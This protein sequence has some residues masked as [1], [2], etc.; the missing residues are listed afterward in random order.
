MNIKK[1][2]DRP[3][4]SIVISVFIVLLGVI[5]LIGLPIEKYPNI[6][7]PT[8]TI[9]TNY[10]GASADAIQNSVIMPIEEAVNGVDDMIYI[11]S[12]ASNSGDVDISVYFKQG[13][14]ADMAAVNVQNR[15]SQVLGLLPAEVTKVGVSVNKRQPSMLRVFTLYSPGHT[16]DEA[17][18][19]NYLDINVVPALKRISG[20]GMT[21]LLASK[22]GMRV[23]VDPVMMAQYNLV[24][25]DIIAVLAEQNIEAPV[26]AFG[27]NADQTFL[28]SMKYRGRNVTEDEFEKIVIKTLPDG[29]ELYLRDVARLELGM[30]SYNFRDLANGAPG[31]CVMVFQVAG[32]NAT[33]I[34]IKIDKLFEELKA[35]MPADL[36]FA[37]LQNSNDFLFASIHNVT[38]SLVIAIILVILVV[39]FFLQDI[40]ATIIPSIS[41]IVSLLGTFVFLQVAGYTLNLL[42]L[43][44]LVLVIGTVVDDTIVIVEA[45]Q[46]R[47]DVGYKSAHKAIC[48][49]VDGLVGSLF[50]TTLVFMMVFIPV[51][52][53]GGTTG[54]FYR[55][56]GLSMAVAVG[57]SLLCAL[58]LAPA[59]CA[60]M[61][62]PQENVSGVTAWVKKVYK[63]SYD[64]LLQRYSKGVGFFIKRRF[65]V[66][67]ILVVGFAMLVA[68][69]KTTKTGMV[70][71]EDKGV[72]FVDYSCPAGY[73]VS[74]TYRVMSQIDSCVRTIPEVENV[75]AVSGYGLLGGVASNSGLMFVKLKPWEERT[76]ANTDV[77]SVMT[78]IY[79]ATAHIKAAQ[80]F[81]M[82]PPMIDGYGSG[83]GFEFWV[84]DKKGGTT[85]ELFEVT[86]KFVAELSARPEIGAAY[87]SFDVDYP[88]YVVDVDAVKCRKLGVSP[89]A[90]LSCMSG[91]FGGTYASNFNR[92]S[93]VYKVMVQGE[94]NQTNTEESL[95]NIYVRLDNGNMAPVSQFISMKKVYEPIKLY[96]FNLYN[97]I[98]ISG[99]PAG[100]CSSGQ[101]INTIKEVAKASL[102]MGYGIDFAGMT[103]EEEENGGG[104]LGFVFAICFLFIYLIMAAL[105]ESFLTPFA[106]ILSVPIGLLGAFVFAKFMGLQNDI[107]LQV[108][109][110]MLIGLLSK[111]AI[112]LTEYATQCRKAGMSLAQ[113][114][115]FAAKMRLRPILMTVLT[116]IFGMLPMIVSTGS[117]ANAN[118]TIGAGT[119]GGMIFGTLALLFLVPTMFIFFQ[120]LQ[121]KV[122]PVVFETTQDPVIQ[123]EIDRLN[124]ESNA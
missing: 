69:L 107:Y 49:A 112:L 16:Y 55:Q 22:Y 100:N 28:R 29:G 124:N 26:G 31:V 5:S 98:N 37:T 93:K 63:T 82:A 80:L 88:Q 89:Q 7:P 45:V 61:M 9:S 91:Y 76:E 1:F 4:L 35:T 41:I 123:A 101:A 19:A 57:I 15:V 65:M 24:P 81:C 119:I 30:E 121:E 47:F 111:T 20:V 40:R 114:A 18:I 85:R 14:N 94:P 92:F 51:S 74:E 27:N 2:I 79:L 67:I 87:C 42:T 46:E 117:G 62:K 36:E 105:Y 83:N 108:G 39:F 60:I 44:A 70:P 72:I 59:L 109:M 38:E 77:N 84:Q 66:V 96:R 104:N 102:P 99:Q 95:R 110:V 10:Y 113:A 54:V 32:S 58:T 71:E 25:N 8:V 68:M 12:N 43:F 3:V 78:K 33:E 23:W 56:F 50:T 11:T 53:M 21:Q 17:F 103:R 34:N 6:A 48:D 52:F 97:A 64:A 122:K 86:K 116:M 90:V 106:I 115:F 118:R 73:N 13:T 75:L 120:S